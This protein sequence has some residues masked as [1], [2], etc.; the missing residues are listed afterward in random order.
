MPSL[1]IPHQYQSDLV[2]ILALENSVFE[3]ILTALKKAVPSL[4]IDDLARN[5]ESEVENT[6]HDNLVKILESIV[7]LYALNK[8]S[9]STLFYNFCRNGNFT[10]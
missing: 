6:N 8:S 3:A 9:I 10:P 7:P 5:V 4:H 2:K 1:K